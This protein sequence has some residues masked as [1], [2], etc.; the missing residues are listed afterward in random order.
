MLQMIKQF[1]RQIIFSKFLA[2]LLIK[3]IL[4][5]HN[6]TYMFS[7]IYANILNDGVHPKFHIIKYNDWFFKNIEDNWNVLDIGCNTGGL[8]YHLSKKANKVYGIEIVEKLVHEAKRIRQKNNIEYIYAD[9]T[10]YNYSNCD[11]IDCV[12]LSN[13]LEHIEMR[14]E[15][16]SKVKE[17]VQWKNENKKFFLIRVPM[18]NRDWITIYKKDLG[19]EWRLDRT[20][21]IEYTAEIFKREI[22]ASGLQILNIEVKFGEIY[23]VC[24]AK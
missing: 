14:I 2:K 7:G 23:A 11:P 22:D 17:A 18:I 3:P 19:V 21:Y 1:I 12:T 6:L 16:L 5:L 4:K 20:H 24:K 10:I 8:A 13:V 9:A 15:F